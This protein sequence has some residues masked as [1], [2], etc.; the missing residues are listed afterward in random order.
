MN[1]WKVFTSYYRPYRS[2]IVFYLMKLLWELVKIWLVNTFHR[3]RHNMLRI[4][5]Q[6]VNTSLKNERYLQDIEDYIDHI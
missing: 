1:K 3:G 4:I 6:L 2:Y 5:K